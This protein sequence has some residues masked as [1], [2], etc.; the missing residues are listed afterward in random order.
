M[1]GNFRYQIADR[2]YQIFDKQIGNSKMSE[3]K[4]NC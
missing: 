3:A 1:N 4:K 2:N